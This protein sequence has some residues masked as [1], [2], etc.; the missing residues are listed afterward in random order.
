MVERLFNKLKTKKYKLQK[1]TL[2]QD[3][4][5]EQKP[6]FDIVLSQ[7]DNFLKM[8]ISDDITLVDFVERMK[9][10]DTFGIEPMISNPVMWNSSKQRVNKG[11]YYIIVVD[12]RLYNILISNDCII[13]DEK[14][15]INEITE[16]RIIRLENNDYWCTFFKHDATGST[17]YTKYYNTR[18][19]SLG[20]LD[21]TKEET[22]E[23]FRPV[24]ENL[25]NIPGIEDILDLDTI[26]PSGKTTAKKLQIPKP[27]TS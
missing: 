21:L 22:V 13:I 6:S 7:K 10:V 12:N 18:G 11:A 14:T 24:I 15:K 25:R 3:T 5:E 1:P 9:E 8:E 17:F 27:P 4:P 19:F 2:N 20:A 23:T 26:D 16:E